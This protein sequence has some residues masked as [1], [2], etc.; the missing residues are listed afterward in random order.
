MLLLFKSGGLNCFAFFL[1]CAHSSYRCCRGAAL[2]AG[3]LSGSEAGPGPV[4]QRHLE[5]QQLLLSPP[6]L[7][8]LPTLSPP[9]LP[10]HIPLFLY[11]CAFIL[12]YNKYEIYYF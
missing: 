6:E 2:E 11:W 9:I 4:G 12:I 3:S 5:G 8:L 7:M 1:P 10:P